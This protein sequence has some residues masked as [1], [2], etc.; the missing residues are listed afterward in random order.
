MKSLLLKCTSVIFLCALVST[1]FSCNG[2]SAAKNEKA[3]LVLALRAGAYAEAVKHSL[4]EFEAEHNVKCIVKELGQEEL[5]QGLQD[6]CDLCMVDSQWV[7]SFYAQ[8]KLADLGEL[9]FRLDRDIIPATTA[10]CRHNGGL[11]LAPYYGNV[12]VLLYN[13]LIAKEA[14]F[15]SYEINSIEDM[16]EICKFANKRHLIGFMYRGDT[17]FNIVTDFLPVLLSYGGWLVDKN[18]NPTVNAPEFQ[19][20]LKMYMELTATGRSAKKADLITAI[21]VKSAAMTIGW[22]GWYTPKK[23]S[24]MEY[25]ALTGKVSN[26]SKA[27]ASNIYGTWML[28]IPAASEHKQLAIELLKHLMDAKVQ[29]ETIPFGGVPCRYSCLRNEEILKKYPEYEI[30]CNALEKGVYRPVIAEWPEFCDILGPE[31]AAAMDKSKSIEYALNTAQE[32][33]EELLKK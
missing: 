32:K 6:S 26:T 1:F 12:T 29:K 7:A 13:S 11:Y 17:N 4:P 24:S 18:N 14:G 16:L 8:N 9:G 2:K 23:N 3:E 19:A 33:L 31:M 5:R 28:G 21:E 20:A 30:V 22:P 25:T 15:A 10:I 27:F